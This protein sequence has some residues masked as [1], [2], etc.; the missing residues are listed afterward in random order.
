MH[1]QRTHIPSRLMI[2]GLALLA[3]LL[4][5]APSALASDGCPNEQVREESNINLTTHEPYDLQL[6]ECRAYE[7]VSPV[8]KQAHDANVA[9]DGPLVSPTGDAIGFGS[10][11]AFAGAEN[12][13]VNF[14]PHN[15]YVA[16]RLNNGWST[17]SASAPASVIS[18]PTY[19]GFNGD[20]GLSLAV[21]DTCG[22]VGDVT[23]ANGNSPVFACAVRNPNGF[24]TTTPGYMALSG[25]SPSQNVFF[26][27]SSA[28]L[29]VV[30]WQPGEHVGL[31]PGDDV[32]GGAGAIYETTGLGSDA[33]QLRM[34][35]VNNENMP[36]TTDGGDYGPDLG[37]GNKGTHLN[38][39]IYQAI[40][41]DG[42]TVY[43]TAEPAGGG[44]LTLFARTG[45][46]GGGTPELPTT[47]E[48]AKEATYWGA[49]SDGSK[50]FYTTTDKLASTDTDSTSD[51]Y[52]YNF[53]SP[54]GHHYTQV[55]AGGLGDPS[56]GSG[57]VVEGVTA[58]SSDGS[59]VYFFSQ[60]LLTTLP[61]D[62]GQHAVAGATNLYGYD[63]ET[64]ETK[65]VAD[66]NGGASNLQVT[67]DGRYLVFETPAHLASEDTNDGT[68][69]Y[70]YD[71]QT[72]QVTWVSHSAPGFVGLNEGDDAVLPGRGE[73]LEEDEAMAFYPDARRAISENGE[74]II[75]ES[76]ERLQPSDASSGSQLYLWHNGEV[77]LI[78]GGAAGEAVT[79]PPGMS[80]NGSDIVFSTTTQLVAQDKDK[81]QDIYD[82]R[83][84]GGFP[85]P[86]PEPS[87]A[88]EA[89]QGS[90]SSAPTF[91]ALGTQ[92]FTGG[93]NQTAPRFKEVLEPETKPKSKPLTEAQK[94][95]KALNACRARNRLKRRRL[96][97]EK[98]ARK[99]YTSTR[100]ATGKHTPLTKR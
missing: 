95:S 16:I 26:W 93:G 68:A 60:A 38:G 81:L 85:A 17:E 30:V 88:G 36:L 9:H 2:A 51:L 83:I 45:D 7:M 57:A 50:V 78:S 6:P 39:N 25:E 73:Y 47:I 22:N 84:D 3:M 61:N 42:Q 29:S 79:E 91:G 41:A 32:P 12:Y 48:I 96:S 19:E 8:D 34:V 90:P 82:A 100:K 63:T 67:P 65:F 80:A 99:R 71:F 69:I 24:W 92:S 94:L 20:A 75:F 77:H 58:I 52:E 10:E 4:L 13:L 76:T 23:G 70:R 35:S 53:D 87:C 89:C 97:C 86:T 54:P 15:T 27:G 18:K 74:Y 1:S 43:F 28:D 72:G 40:S 98:A 44:P 37:T 46:F 31:L 56:P 11:G 66:M 64:S 33:S 49:S 55:S 14:N 59:H 62:D 5:S 21:F